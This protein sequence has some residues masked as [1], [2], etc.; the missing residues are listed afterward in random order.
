MGY[1]V[2]ANAKEALQNG[3]VAVWDIEN[4][5]ELWSFEFPSVVT[6]VAFSPSGDL[7]AAAGLDGS[8]RT[9]SVTTGEEHC[10]L[11]AQDAVRAISFSTDGSRIIAGTEDRLVM[12]WSLPDR[13]EIVLQQGTTGVRQFD[14]DA[15]SISFGNGGL[16]VGSSFKGNVLI[17]NS[18]TGRLM[19]NFAEGGRYRRIALAPSSTWLAGVSP[20]FLTDSISGEHTIR[21]REA[22]SEKGFSDTEQGSLA[23]AISRDEDSVAVATGKNVAHVYSA[24]TGLRTHTFEVRDWVSSVAFSPDVKLLAVGSAFWSP[25]ADNRGALKVFDLESGTVVLPTMDFPLDVWWLAFSPNGELLAAAMGDYQDVGA[26]LGRIR[27][28]NTRSWEVVHELRGHS[29]CVWSLSFNPSSSRLASAGGQWYR[30]GSPVG[31]A[32]VWDMR[33][34]SELLAIPEPNGA[35][36]GVAFSPDGRRLALASYNG[37]VRLVDGSELVETPKHV[38][39]PLE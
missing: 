35:V 20:E 14:G 12:L 17:W 10:V 25:G 9:W 33:T 19:R 34:G 5:K 2:P 32:K 22:N 23:Y 21:L 30:R 18:K 31:E 13:E 27:V 16:A 8:V 3:G 28:W 6:C 39:M 4:K 7:F 1:T 15:N 37:L 36:F 24:S 26:D 38:P 29:R 11:F